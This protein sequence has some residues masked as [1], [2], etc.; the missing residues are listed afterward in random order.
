MKLRTR[1]MNML[2]V[3]GIAVEKMEAHTSSKS[4]LPII[5]NQMVME[6]EVRG[7]ISIRNQLQA[8]DG[9]RGTNLR[10]RL[11]SV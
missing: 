7:K 5:K 11:T 4:P 2:R 10:E 9:G 1:L 3:T 8:L 6:A